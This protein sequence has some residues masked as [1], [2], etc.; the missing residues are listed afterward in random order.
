[1]RMCWCLEPPTSEFCDCTS[2]PDGVQERHEG[3]YWFR[4]NIPTSSSSHLCPCTKFVVG[5]TNGRER[6]RAPKFLVECACVNVSVNV[7]T[8]WWGSPFPFYKSKGREWIQRER[9]RE[10]DPQDRATSPLLL[11]GPSGPVDDGGGAPI[12]RP[13]A[14]GGVSPNRMGG[15]GLP[16]YKTGDVRPAEMGGG[17]PPAHF[18]A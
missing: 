6:E 11:M 10:R 17:S 5:V 7:S 18:T 4:Q 16:G 15:A 3:L 14:T 9:E 8:P 12:P 13:D 2:G 1:M